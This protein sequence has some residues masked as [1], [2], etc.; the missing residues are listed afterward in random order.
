[1][2][3]GAAR[4]GGPWN[5][6]R[7]TMERIIWRSGRDFLGATCSINFGPC[8]SVAERHLRRRED[9]AY[10]R[11]FAAVRTDHGLGE[12]VDLLAHWSVDSTVA[13]HISTRPARGR[14]APQETESRY[15]LLPRSLQTARSGSLLVG[16]QRDPCP[17]RRVV[18]GP[19]SAARRRSGRGQP[20]ALADARGAPPRQP[21]GALS[22]VGVPWGHWW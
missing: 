11:I 5:D 18:F 8:Q 16:S 20:D 2:P 17:D 13:A 6:S 14:A 1:M 10:A 4:R 9:G 22:C 12:G 19:D 3:S 21:E 15:T 7:H